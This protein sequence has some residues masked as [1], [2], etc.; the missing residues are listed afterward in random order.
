MTPIP[1]EIADAS[2]VPAQKAGNSSSSDREADRTHDSLH[3]RPVPAGLGGSPVILPPA[4][5]ENEIWLPHQ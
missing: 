3:A 5:P 4:V 2:D 1:H